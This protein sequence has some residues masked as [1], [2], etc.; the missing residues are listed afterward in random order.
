MKVELTLD[1]V[2]VLLQVL[3]IA[4]Q[5]LESFGDIPKTLK[6]KKVFTKNVNEYKEHLTNVFSKIDTAFSAYLESEEYLNS[7]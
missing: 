2:F 3:P 5:R 1:E 4:S 6:K 7:L